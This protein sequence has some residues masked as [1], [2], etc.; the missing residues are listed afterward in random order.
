MSRKSCSPDNV[1]CKDFYDRLENELFY[2]RDW[3]HTTIDGFIAE[4]D[5][6]IRWYKEA[7]I[8]ISLGSVGPVEH[9]NSL[10]IAIQQVQDFHSTSDRR[11][12]LKACVM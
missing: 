5:A 2:A 7:R 10:G 6:Y 12:L 9:S 8:K 3:L 4:F 1:A 11:P